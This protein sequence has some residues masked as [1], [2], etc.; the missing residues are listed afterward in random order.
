[1]HYQ[2]YRFPIWLKVAFLTERWQSLADCD[3]LENYLAA[4]NR[5]QGSN[6]CLSSKI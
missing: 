3:S 1:M 6:P 5:H 4:N 2:L